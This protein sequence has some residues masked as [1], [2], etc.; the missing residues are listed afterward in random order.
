MATASEQTKLL[1]SCRGRQ[2]REE[3]SSHGWEKMSKFCLFALQEY[4]AHVKT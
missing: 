1:A 2:W 3:E 4:Q